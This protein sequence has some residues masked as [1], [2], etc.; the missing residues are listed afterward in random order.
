MP[1]PFNLP[2]VSNLLLHTP[3]PATTSPLH[4]LLHPS[5][6]PHVY[7]MGVSSTHLEYMSRC[8]R[9]AF[10]RTITNRLGHPSYALLYGQTIHHALELFYSAIRISQTDPELSNTTPDAE[11]IIAQCPLPPAPV[12]EWR[13]QSQFDETIRRYCDKY[14]FDDFSSFKILEIEKPFTAFIGQVE[15][16]KHIPIPSS[17]LIRDSTSPDHP[18][19][20]IIKIW[21]ASIVD[22]I[23]ERDGELWLM[24]HKTSSI[25]S[26]NVWEHYSL[27]QQFIGYAFAV[28]RILQRPVRGVIANLV[29]GRRPTKT[30]KSIE[31]ERRYYPYSQETQD[32]WQS[33]VFDIVA[34][35]IHCMATNHFPKHTNACETKYSL[36]EYFRVCASCSANR[37]SLLES[38]T[39][40]TDNTRTPLLT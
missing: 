7:D 24:D 8:P 10:Y 37:S 29:I 6:T 34:Y 1:L 28:Q 13:S 11:A 19:A 30:G 35:F 21:W 33:D 4:R 39:D 9:A 27:S 25:V 14:A 16:D 3:L 2:D 18:F 20:S 12:D 31:F 5:S 38:T 15:L 26:S 22:L 32:E 40:F 17:L 36:C 23:V